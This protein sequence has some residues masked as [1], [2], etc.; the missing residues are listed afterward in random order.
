MSSNAKPWTVWTCTHCAAT[1][2]EFGQGH[3]PMCQTPRE[4][5]EQPRQGP[6]GAE[7]VSVP[8][9]PTKRARGAAKARWG[10]CPHTGRAYR[11]KTEARW[12]VERPDHRFEAVGVRTACGV[13]WPDFVYHG[14]QPV[15][16]R[17][18]SAC[19]VS[20]GWWL[21]EVKG[22]HI[23]DRALH[24]VKAAIRPARELGFAGI[25]LAQWDGKKWTVSELLEG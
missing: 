10:R 13:Y 7:P 14:N 12:A 22:A 25:W 2:R 21:I 19:T 6:S 5:T 3:C 8:V 20:R 4:G 17:E 23:R 18:G 11:S 9:R 15:M 16:P 24:K 1:W